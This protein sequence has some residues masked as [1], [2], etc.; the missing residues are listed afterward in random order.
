[1]II[2]DYLWFVAPIGST[3]HITKYADDASLLVSEKNDVGLETK[4][5]NVTKW[6]RE[7]N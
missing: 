4:F 1:M 5:L 7:I 3:K 6:A 2:Y